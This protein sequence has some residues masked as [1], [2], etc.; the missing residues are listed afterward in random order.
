LHPRLLEYDERYRYTTE[1]LVSLRVSA[2]GMGSAAAAGLAGVPG[3]L[4]SS[5]ADSW[6]RTSD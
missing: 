3:E 2:S 4:R 1:Q 5:S 6:R